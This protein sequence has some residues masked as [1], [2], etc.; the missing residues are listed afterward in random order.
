MA[1][2]ATLLPCVAAACEERMRTPSTEGNRSLKRA[3]NPF[4]W[5]VEGS[6]LTDK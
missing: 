1:I 3:A 4:T 5:A 2:C 6:P